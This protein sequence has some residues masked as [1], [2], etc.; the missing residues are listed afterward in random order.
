M[1]KKEDIKQIVLEIAQAAFNKKG[2]DIEILDLEGISMLGDYFLIAS[3]NNIKQSQ[4]IA[5]EMEDKAAELGMTVRHREGYREGE[6][7]LLDFGD[8]ICHVFGGDELREFYSLEELWNDA[9]RVP[10]EGV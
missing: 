5:D 4:S 8:I 2:R 9:G 1:K 6:W 3:A 7:I 10:F